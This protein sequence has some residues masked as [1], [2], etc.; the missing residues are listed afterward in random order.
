MQIYFTIDPVI[1]LNC[2]KVSFEKRDVYLLSPLNY[3][4]PSG[5]GDFAHY[6]RNYLAW[7]DVWIGMI[8]E[9]D[10]NDDTTL[11]MAYQD[12]FENTCVSYRFGIDGLS[13]VKLFLNPRERRIEYIDNED[14]FQFNI[15]NV[16]D[17]EWDVLLGENR[18][19]LIE[20]DAIR[21]DI[22]EKLIE[23]NYN[24]ER[25]VEI[26]GIYSSMRLIVLN[27]Q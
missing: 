20:P 10:L 17:S 19:Y 22:S 23:N 9:L 8:K 3:P 11:Y 6:N 21:T 16:T 24:V 1:L 4:E 14:N 26:E 18:I 27:R 13:K 15:Q 25:Q 2:R 7:N 12:D 5:I